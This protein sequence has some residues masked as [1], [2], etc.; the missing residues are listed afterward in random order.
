[1]VFRVTLPHGPRGHIRGPTDPLSANYVAGELMVTAAAVAVAV[2]LMTI[3]AAV[4]VVVVV[5]AVM[6][7]VVVAVISVVVGRRRRLR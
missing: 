4:A 6:V 5:A 7:L 1:M 3:R 2:A